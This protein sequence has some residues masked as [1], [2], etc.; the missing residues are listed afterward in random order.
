MNMALSPPQLSPPQPETTPSNDCG[1]ME[2]NFA[3]A[4]DI[5]P[6]LSLGS[7]VASMGGLYAGKRRIPRGIHAGGLFT[8]LSECN[9]S[10]I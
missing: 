7:L 3:D 10:W 9:N 5:A 2:V 8:M 4:D 6:P 1:T